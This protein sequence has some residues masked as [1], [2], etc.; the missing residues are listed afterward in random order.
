MKQ[1]I[2]SL[3]RRKRVKHLNVIDFTI[4]TSKE[5]KQV[6]GGCFKNNF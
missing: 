2:K 1:I 4:L 3:F 5:L 6:K